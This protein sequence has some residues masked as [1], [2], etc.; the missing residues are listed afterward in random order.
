[1]MYANYSQAQTRLQIR[2]H[3]STRLIGS[4][5]VN[6]PPTARLAAIWSV[7]MGLGLGLV[8]C[9]QSCNTDIGQSNSSQSTHAAAG[10]AC[11][12]H[13]E[14]G[15]EYSDRDN[16]PTCGM[17]LVTL[18]K[19]PCAVQLVPVPDQANSQRGRFGV[20][21]LGPTGLPMQEQWAISPTAYA[22]NASLTSITPIILTDRPEFIELPAKHSGLH[23]VVGSLTTQGRNTQTFVARC[24]IGREQSR[25]AQ[26]DTSEPQPTKEDWDQVFHVKGHEFRLRCNGEPYTAG[27][28]R[29]FPLRLSLQK[30]GIEVPIDRAADTDAGTDADPNPDAH[31]GSPPELFFVST[32]LM[33]AAFARPAQSTADHVVEWAKRL[34]NGSDTDTV[35]SITFPQPGMYRG[36]ATLLADGVQIPVTFTID[37]KSSEAATTPDHDHAAEH[38]H[39]RK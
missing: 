8:G 33:S 12:M 14:P 36:F 11:P 2:P 17:A 7:V 9:D 18:D 39:D 13:C 19:I 32:D 27:E 37:A 26:T 20:R 3:S 35:Y 34:A 21:V 5:A 24:I 23:V 10:L 38:E 31:V 30:N 29:E 1:M 15:V 22:V 16:C 25:D 6:Y 4:G 28:G